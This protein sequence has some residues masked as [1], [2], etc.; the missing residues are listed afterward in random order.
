ML[1]NMQKASLITLSENDPELI[2]FLTEVGK[3][4]MAP[5]IFAYCLANKITG[6][7]L[8]EIAFNKYRR[9]PEKFVKEFNA[10]INGKVL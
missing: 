8:K 1:T 5:K 6:K 3:F 7:I 4:V 10:T 2:V 9:N